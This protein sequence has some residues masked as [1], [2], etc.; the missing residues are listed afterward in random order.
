MYKYKG[1]A[2]LNHECCGFA[3]VS[4]MFT[5]SKHPRILKKRKVNLLIPP[6]QKKKKKL[7]RAF[8]SEE[9]KRITPTLS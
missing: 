6:P 1:E 3:L 5:K 9:A 4:A 8:W 7:M 2:E